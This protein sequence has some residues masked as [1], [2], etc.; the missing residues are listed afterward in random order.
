L[1]RK[2]LPEAVVKEPAI[3]QGVETYIC[4]ATHFG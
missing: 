2:S 3:L 4:F 1:I